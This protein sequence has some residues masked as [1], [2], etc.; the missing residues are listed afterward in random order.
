MEMEYCAPLGIPHSQFLRWSTDDQDK[1][2]AYEVYKRTV[3][4]KC[5]TIPEDWIDHETGREL[6]DPP[7]EPVTR[8]C[9]G[10]ATMEDAREEIPADRRSLITVFLV[11]AGSR[12]RRN[13]KRRATG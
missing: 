9:Q 8:Y 12:G 3:C 11:R 2:M 5:G 6:D 13:G 4:H 1:A 10:C 7:F